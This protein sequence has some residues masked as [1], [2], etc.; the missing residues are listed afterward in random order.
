[1]AKQEL[2]YDPVRRD[3][4]LYCDPGICDC[5]MYIGQGDFLCTRENEDGDGFPVYVQEAWNPTRHFWWCKGE[6]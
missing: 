3:K 6:H 2:Y 4:K 5:C 1:M